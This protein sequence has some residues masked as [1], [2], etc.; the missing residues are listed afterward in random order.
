MERPSWNESFMLHAILT[1]LRSSCLKRRAGAVL[2]KD[3]RITASGYNGAAPGVKS[4]L[5]SGICFYDSLAWGDS[6]KGIGTFEALREERK[7]FCSAV[8]AEQNA[9]N[10]CSIH[11][12]SAV[13]SI[14]YTTNFP[15][16]ACVRDAIIPNRVAKIFVW[17]EYLQNKQLTLDEWGIS[18]KWL[19]EAGIA[20]CKMD[21]TQKRMAE[22]FSAVSLV[23]VRLPYK[24]YSEEA[25]S[26]A[27][28]SQS[29]IRNLLDL[30]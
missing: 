16:P 24:F 26:K 28:S 11:G 5:E 29:E 9:I 14:L 17:K 12:I 27:D 18:S 20:I 2:V 25:P 13:D 3:N 7:L 30:I 6:Q 4:C 15:C 21:F 19:S 23:G 22:L 10:Q 1:A 8:H